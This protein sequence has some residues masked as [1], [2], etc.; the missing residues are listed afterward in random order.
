MT[1]RTTL[2]AAALCLIIASPA[3]AG[4]HGSHHQNMG[5]AF[6]GGNFNV[7]DDRFLQ[8]MAKDERTQLFTDANVTRSKGLFHRSNQEIWT[9]TGP[10]CLV[11]PVQAGSVNGGNA[12]KPKGHHSNNLI[13]A[14]SGPD[15]LVAPVQAPGLINIVNASKQ[16]HQEKSNVRGDSENK[17]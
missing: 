9:N 16:S 8:S 7:S 14:N 15:C 11:A 6:K 13:W 1:Y 5:H 2:A 12:S 17:R 4:G 3:F 10:D